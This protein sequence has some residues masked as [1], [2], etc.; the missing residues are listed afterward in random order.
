MRKDNSDHAGGVQCSRNEYILARP[1]GKSR[2][3]TR[4]PSQ[5]PARPMACTLR[6]AVMKRYEE[7]MTRRRNLTG[8]VWIGFHETANDRGREGIEMTTQIEKLDWKGF[9]DH[10]SRDLDGWETLIEVFSNDV[11]AQVISQGLPFHGLTVEDKDGEST[12]ELIVGNSTEGHNIANAVKVAFE[13]TGVG[14]SGILDIEDA[15]GTKTLIRFVQPFPVLLEYVNTE[16]VRV[17]AN[18]E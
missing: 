7:M 8:A 5:Q 16:I 3:T 14:P 6:L 11:G 18:G 9:F 2:D 13:G 1:R 10:L 17:A 15:S 4:G 12:I